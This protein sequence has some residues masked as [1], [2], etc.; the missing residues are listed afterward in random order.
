MLLGLDFIPLDQSVD[1]SLNVLRRR[2]ATHDKTQTGTR[3][4]ELS[5]ALDLRHRVSASGAHPLSF[6]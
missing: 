5:V 2:V 1:M 4:D 3:M 6:H